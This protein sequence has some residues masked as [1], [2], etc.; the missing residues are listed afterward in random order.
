MYKLSVFAEKPNILN[1]SSSSALVNDAL[2]VTKNMFLFAAIKKL[3]A[4]T[5]P[6]I[7]LFPF[8]MTPSKS[9]QK[10]WYF[11]TIFIILLKQTLTI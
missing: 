5:L 4:S 10:F 8:H 2:F 3:M 9:M 7:E 6:G 1:F 11:S